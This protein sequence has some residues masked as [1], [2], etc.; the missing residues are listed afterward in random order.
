MRSIDG[1]V[2]NRADGKVEAVFAAKPEMVDALIE[3]CKT[4]PGQ[5]QVTGI[6]V[7]HYPTDPGPGFRITF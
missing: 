1:W 5:A 7:L 4:G 6:D 3:A 2:R